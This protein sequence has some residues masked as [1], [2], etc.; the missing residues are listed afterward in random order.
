[1]R[2][3]LREL[4]KANS[5]TKAISK[6]KKTEIALEL[7]KLR[8][9]REETPPVASVPG[10]KSK[11]MESKITDVK[12][13]KEKEFPVAPSKE[14]KAPKK[15][16]VVGGGGAIGVETKMSKKDMLRKMLEEM[17]DD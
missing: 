7:E 9:R 14:K 15:A 6:M 10:H 13:A 4:R 5:S 2:D 11:A 17:D 3:E 1:M 12:V 8:G 16:T